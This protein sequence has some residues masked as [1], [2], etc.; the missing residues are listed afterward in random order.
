L[1]IQNPLYLWVQKIIVMWFKNKSL[2]PLLFLV[3]FTTTKTT[4]QQKATD[5]KLFFE[6]LY[7]HTDR[8]FYAGGD[9]IWFKIYLVNAQN[10]YLFNS[11]NTVYA[12]LINPYNSIVSRQVIRVDSGYGTGDFKLDDSIAG[13]S[14]RIRAYT[15]WMRNFG[16]HFIF[17][18]QLLVKNVPGEQK[19]SA[20]EKE[21][22][23]VSTTVNSTAVYNI[24]FFPEGGSLVEG[25]ASVL[26]FKATDING[27]GIDASGGIVSNTGDTVA[28]FKTEHAGMGSFVFTAAAGVQYKTFIQYPG[29]VTA[30][31]DIEP[32]LKIGYSMQVTGTNTETEQVTV[33]SNAATA[34]VYPSGQIT[35]AVKH[36][37]KI[38]RK[39]KLQLKD[40]QAV[41]NLPVKDLPAGICSITLYDDSLHPHCER[42]I[43]VPDNDPL[44]INITT[45]KN[46]YSAKEKVTVSISVTG[47]DQQPIKTNLSMAV[48]DDLVAAAS[49]HSIVSYLL[50]QS[51]VRG[52]I[53]N[54][55]TYF[56]EKN[57]QRLQQL[58]L[59][60]RTQGWRDFLWRRMAD[61]AINIRYMP[62]QGISIS[63]K[64]KQKLGGKPLPGMNITLQVPGAKDNKWF[65]TRS[66]AQGNYFLDGIPLYGVQT[67]KLSAK[68]DKAEKRGELFMDSLFSDRL[69][70]SAAVSTTYD[71]TAFLRFAQDAAKRYATEKNNKWFNMLPGV[72]VSSKKSTMLL[73]DGAY[74]SFG[75]PEDNFTIT[76]ADYVYDDLRNFL[77]KKVPGTFYDMDNDG[78]Y[79]MANGKK[80]RPRFVVDKRE[81]VFDRIDYYSLSMKQVVS[82]S[83]RHV[84]GQPSF[85]RTELEDGNIRDLGTSPTDLFIVY[86]V[87]KPGALDGDASKITTEVTGYYQA[88]IFYAPNYNTDKGMADQRTTIHWEPFI[89]TDKNGK[90]TI[91]FY[92]ADPKTTIRIDVQGVSN[93]GQPVAGEKKYVVE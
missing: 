35:I 82:V 76:S 3:L 6:K 22:T 45:N 26:S 71:T 50:L 58:D 91:S 33:F 13:G 63:G 14:Y 48:V 80:I 30:T 2:L 54:A 66:N 62:E 8:D 7:L 90:A 57:P 40:N 42:L 23:P 12:E 25:I 24:S 17:E 31:E 4:A 27:N 38:L 55:T 92:N 87:L 43:Y 39:E 51:E 15:N 28:R 88:R 64:V 19:I 60:L 11:S 34:A 47:K 70:V 52:R 67:I 73:S 68:N 79:F 36:A 85:T 65:S 32:A 93:K 18:K 74:M 75:Y 5:I 10:N 89:S 53:E 9:D 83:V 61:T 77:G 84:L 78:V 21:A 56:D 69:P 29:H 16:A 46:N 86:L 81:D 41:L 49:D 59:L 20:A 44:H 1:V 72:T 37:G